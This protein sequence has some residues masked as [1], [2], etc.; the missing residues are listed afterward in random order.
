MVIEDKKYGIDE[1]FS[2]IGEE[3]LSGNNDGWKSKSDMVV[4]GFNVHT[5]SLRYMTFYQKGVKCV[6]CGKEGTHFKLCGEDGSNRRH[7]NL[8]ADDG[9]LITKDHIIPASK[10]G[11]DK[12]SNMQTMCTVCNGAK[13][14]NSD[15]KFEYIVASHTKKDSEQK[16]R[17]MDTAVMWAANTYAGCNSKKV[18]KEDAMKIVA[19]TYSKILMAIE[20]GIPVYNHVW[21]KEMR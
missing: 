17:S 14:N 5:K 3:H 9:T 20:T 2:M 4:D 16:F 13:G 21:T 10:G 7:F 8:Y 11:P 18:K 15:V 6:C 12:A 19:K 1:V